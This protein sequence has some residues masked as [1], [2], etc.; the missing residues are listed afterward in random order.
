MEHGFDVHD[1]FVGL[2]ESVPCAKRAL[3][4]RHVAFVAVQQQHAADNLRCVLADLGVFV[5]NIKMIQ[6]LLLVIRV[7]QELR[8]SRN[9]QGSEQHAEQVGKHGYAAGY[10]GEG[11]PVAVA[12][13]GH[14]HPNVP[15][16]DGV[17]V[18]N[19]TKMHCRKADGTHMWFELST[20]SA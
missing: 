11:D 16:G 17:H 10:G 20:L 6:K 8:E 5:T 4:V 2:Q 12:D 7:R 18:Q 15:P 13:G 1:A 3:E 9:E 19:V 14:G